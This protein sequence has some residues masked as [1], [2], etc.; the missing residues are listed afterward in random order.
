MMIIETMIITMILRKSETPST[1]N[2]NCSNT[3]SFF[4]LFGLHRVLCCSLENSHFYN[5]KRLKK[6][7][8]F[9]SLTVKK[10]SQLSSW[11]Q[12]LVRNL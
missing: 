3:C 6:K 10:A 9:I 11:S 5:E 4:S 7:E 8:N 12:T 1:G 2:E